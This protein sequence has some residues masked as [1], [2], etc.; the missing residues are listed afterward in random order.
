MDL[1]RNNQVNIMA[2]L[3]GVCASIIFFTHVL[4]FQNKKVKRSLLIIEI[5]TLIVLTADRYAYYFRGDTSY[6][7]YWMVRISNFLVFLAMYLAE[8]FFSLYVKYNFERANRETNATKRLHAAFAVSLFGAFLVILSQFTGLFYTI[9]EENVYQR[10]QGYFVCMLVHFVTIVLQ[11]S[12]IIQYFK[13]FSKRIRYSL[14]AY[15]LIPV[16]SA[17]L[18]LVCYGISFNTFALSASCIG[19]FIFALI[20]LNNS[21]DESRNREKIIEHEFR[22]N[23]E[24]LFEQTIAVLSGSIDAKDKYTQGH[25]QRVAD[26]SKQLAKMIGLPKEEQRVLYYS[27]LLH[28][29]GKIG[30]NDTII[31]KEG[32]LTDEEYAEIKKH[33]QIGSD[34]LEKI[35]LFPALRYGALYH[36]ERYDGKGYPKGMKGDD[37][38]LTARIIS[39]ADAYD[40]M[41]SKRS[42]REIIPQQHVREQM[43]MGMGTQFDP[44]IA[45][46]MVELIDK[47]FEYTMREQFKPAAIVEKTEFK[48]A[49][50]LSDCSRSLW[51]ISVP[52]TIKVK[53]V[54]Y[55]KQRDVFSMPSLVVFDSLDEKVH[56][57]ENVQKEMH[58]LEFLTVRA[59][60]E[61]HRGEFRDIRM[62]KMPEGD[63]DPERFREA[64]EE[65]MEIS[66][67]MTRYKDHLRIIL[68]N[69]FQKIEYIVAVQDSIRY[70]YGAITGENCDVEILS[71][72]KA[73]AMVGPDEIPR[74]A[75]ELSYADGPEGDI[76]N[77]QVPAWRF[78]HS[79]EIELRNKTD[80]HFRALSLPTSRLIW[81]CPFIVVFSSDDGK[82]HGDGYQE[83]LL[84][85]MDGE[86]WSE[87]ELVQCSSYINKSME[88]G[89]WSS[90]KENNKRGVDGTISISQNGNSLVITTENSGLTCVSQATLPDTANGLYAVLTGDQC[91]ITNIRITRTEG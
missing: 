39:V 40:A 82:Y 83:Y 79:E 14:L 35:T 66:Y 22:D 44:E 88:F 84:I 23:M 25:S 21:L 75:P 71:V 73:K 55:D 76:P 2:I 41:T 32:R 50:Y 59:D 62:N 89:D 1:I 8:G 47:D 87:S 69:P 13:S 60:G 4:K 12:F 30:I 31:N 7:G 26:Y 5:L 53:S 42:Y 28:D 77:I 68:T 38:P 63:V 27:A 74:I 15:V 70:S 80:I 37:I 16:V 46:K 64:C 85:R 34:I 86:C 61:I 56:T 58:Y 10:S 48:F 18:Q 90:W 9:N 36:H 11:T 33:S 6:I 52:T 24:Q 72:D 91:A 3:M 43:V 19:L 65:G 45:T 54:T 20:D 17:L 78:V 49:E 29:V 57:K 81:H 67:E 51:I